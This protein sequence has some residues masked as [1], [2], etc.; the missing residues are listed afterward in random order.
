[1]VFTLLNNI[2]STIH[3]YFTELEIATYIDVLFKSS[4]M[5]YLM[6]QNLKV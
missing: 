6:T 5:L 3:Q 2:R 4:N 1:M